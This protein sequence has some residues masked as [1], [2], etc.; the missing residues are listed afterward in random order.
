MRVEAGSPPRHQPTMTAAIY[1]GTCWITCP[2]DTDCRAS[3]TGCAGSPTATTPNTA[4][5]PGVRAHFSRGGAVAAALRRRAD[6]R[7]THRGFRGPTDA[8][9]RRLHT[10][11]YPALLAIPG[12]AGAWTFGSSTGWSHLPRGRQADHQYITVIYLD[13]DPLTTTDA[14][15]P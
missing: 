13:D 8:W 15:A 3:C 14:L 10:E 12:T 2:S 11:N 7:R 6:R 1:G 5:P 4:W 9:L